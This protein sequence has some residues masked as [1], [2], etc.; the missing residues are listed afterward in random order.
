MFLLYGA[1]VSCVAT[2]EPRV[3]ERVRDAL[4]LVGYELGLI[5]GKA[6]PMQRHPPRSR[7]LD[8]H[9]LS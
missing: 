1:L 9:F 8:P 6:E 2:R 5:A 4:R 7:D 3:R